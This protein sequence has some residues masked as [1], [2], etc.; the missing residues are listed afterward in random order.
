HSGVEYLATNRV[1]LKTAAITDIT[2]ATWG[3][4]SGKAWAKSLGI[5]EM[6]DK[7][8]P[9]KG[10][11]K[12]SLRTVGA[13][14]V[15]FGVLGLNIIAGVAGMIIAYGGIEAAIRHDDKIALWSYRMIMISGA[16]TTAGGAV[17][18]MT[19]GAAKGTLM[20]GL[21]SAMAPVL[22]VAAIIAII[23]GGIL[24]FFAKD[25]LQSWL[26]T[27]FWG[28][29]ENYPFWRLEEREEISRQINDAKILANL[30]AKKASESDIPTEESFEYSRIN[31]GFIEELY[32]YGILGGLQVSQLSTGTRFVTIRCAEFSKTPPN[33]TNLIVKYSV[34]RE[35]KLITNKLTWK[36][37]LISQSFVVIDLKEE[38]ITD[39]AIRI[40]ATFTDKED[41]EFEG[42]SETVEY[43]NALTKIARERGSGYWPIYGLREV[44]R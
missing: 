39:K 12:L 4:A 31:R 25:E 16:V 2:L 10:A 15:A 29:S 20:A 22:F 38:K 36:A 9:P 34:I 3:V 32:E 28:N 24:F 37:Q 42:Y 23:A 18:I 30:E 41:E 1:L 8:V 21:G 26:S 11:G 14:K 35:G 19:A 13:N 33:T 17:S 40:D 27:G 44:K 6:P 43:K 7:I 5:P